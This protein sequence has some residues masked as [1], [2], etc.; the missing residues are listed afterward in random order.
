[1]N[2][3]I[4]EEAQSQA[5]VTRLVNLGEVG[6]SPCPLPLGFYETDRRL[7]WRRPGGDFS[8][9]WLLNSILLRAH[10]TG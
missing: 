9:H 6:V 4:Y 8:S 7:P 10:S 3:D 1:M 5:G 2:K